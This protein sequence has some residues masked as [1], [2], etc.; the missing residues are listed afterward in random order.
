MGTIFKRTEVI[1]DGTDEIDARILEA[2]L[3]RRYLDHAS[4]VEHIDDLGNHRSR[5]NVPTYTRS[6]R[7]L[8]RLQIYIN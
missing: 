4:L 8:L 3:S 6:L 7:P 1:A 5:R 2:V